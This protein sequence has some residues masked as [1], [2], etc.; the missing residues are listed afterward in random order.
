MTT[1]PGVSVEQ[2]DQHLG[3]ARGTAYPWHEHRG[4]PEREIAVVLPSAGVTTV[5]STEFIVLRP[6]KETTLAV[7]AC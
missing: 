7:D 1:E 4:L 5:A 6:T 3:L 2:A